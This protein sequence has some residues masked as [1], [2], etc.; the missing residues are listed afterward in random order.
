MEEKTGAKEAYWHTKARGVG[1]FD[2]EKDD[3]LHRDAKLEC[4]DETLTE[5]QYFSFC[6]PNERVHGALCFYWYPNIGQLTGGVWAWQGFKPHHLACEIFDWRQHMSDKILTNDLWDYTMT[7]GYGM[8]MIKPGKEFHAHYEDKLHQSSCEIHYTAIMEP[9]V[10]GSHNHIE[11]HMKTEGE[12]VM[13]GRKYPVYGYGVRNRSWGQVRS[14][15]GAPAVPATY[16]SGVFNDNCSFYCSMFDDPADH[17]EWEGKLIRPIDSCM[18]NG[19][20]RK[21]GET[22]E[23]VDGHKLLIRNPVT[24]F[25]ERVE[26]KLIDSKGREHKVNGM[27]Q[28]LSSFG[29]WYNMEVCVC[30]TRWEGEAMVG[31]GDTQDIKLGDFMYLNMNK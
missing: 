30:Q 22:L 27:M 14:E 25:P 11:Q 7:M 3:F 9:F 19:F 31:Y 10:I 23:L 26:L 8:R 28:A 24:L 16:I 21:D 15:A 17:P 29:M 13:R 18:V 1:E 5:S 4:T 6:M 20:W 2:Y 12:L